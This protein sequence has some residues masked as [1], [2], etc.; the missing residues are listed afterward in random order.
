[1]LGMACAFKS[2]I[3]LDQANQLFDVWLN[4]GDK[5][6]PDIRSVVYRYGIVTYLLTIYLCYVSELHEPYLLQSMFF[7]FP[8]RLGQ[9]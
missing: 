9:R 6:H 1:M 4:G 2:P 5:P 3:D 8:A 7:F